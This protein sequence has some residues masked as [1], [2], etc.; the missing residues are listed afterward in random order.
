MMEEFDISL[1]E[2]GDDEHYIYAVE[3]G[4]TWTFQIAFAAFNLSLFIAIA[5]KYGICITFV[6]IDD[7]YYPVVCALVIFGIMI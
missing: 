1:D 5:L 7:S 2:H 3:F 6:S 4:T